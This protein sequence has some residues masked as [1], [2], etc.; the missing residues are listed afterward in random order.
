MGKNQHVVPKN[1]RWGVRGENN[2]KLTSTFD[3][4]A[5]A[6]ARAREIS[7]NQ[8]SELLIH[9]RNGRIRER[10]SYGNDPYPPRG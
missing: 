2:S 5:E 10:D 6:I 9:S 1:G 7:R 4:Q 3:T 8:Q